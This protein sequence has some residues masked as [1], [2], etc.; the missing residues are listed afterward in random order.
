MRIEITSKT[1]EKDE[2]LEAYI[3]R[4]IGKLEK[5]MGSHARKSAHAEVRLREVNDKKQKCEC[6]VTLHMPRHNVVVKEATINMYAAVDIVAEKLKNQ[7]KKY[8]DLNDTHKSRVRRAARR[9]KRLVFRSS[10][11]ELISVEE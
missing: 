4:K 3:T 7:L 1:K 9:V 5:Y 6:E 10:E 11:A 8:H 2:K